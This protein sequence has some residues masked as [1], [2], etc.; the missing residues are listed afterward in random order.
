MVPPKGSGLKK[1]GRSDCRAPLVGGARGRG[2]LLGRPGLIR[3]GRL[4][5]SYR[6]V[7]PKQ[8]PSRAGVE[9]GSVRGRR[10]SRRDAR[11]G[12]PIALMW[13]TNLLTFAKA[14]HL[15]A[16]PRFHWLFDAS[17]DVSGAG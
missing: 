1:P 16:S 8:V 11:R 6:L 9:S 12:G 10:R 7:R 3:F 15:G 17:I 4:R 2:R 14:P 13:E 5:S